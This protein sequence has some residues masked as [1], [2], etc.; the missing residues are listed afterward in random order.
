MIRKISVLIILIIAIL[1]IFALTGCKKIENDENKICIFDEKNENEVKFDISKKLNFEVINPNTESDGNSATY[2]LINKDEK[3]NCELDLFI[4][5]EP[6]STYET[7]K[8]LRSS[9][10][11]FKEYNFNNYTGYVYGDKD[12]DVL[13]IQ[14]ILESDGTYNTIL[15]GTMSRYS[16]SNETISYNVFNSA[17]IQ[18]FFNTIEFVKKK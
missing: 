16:F 9:K 14:I 8:N 15:V 5:K 4:T 7:E 3:I 17:E 1:S 6:I 2:S 11:Y 12:S 10:E 18:E 13:D